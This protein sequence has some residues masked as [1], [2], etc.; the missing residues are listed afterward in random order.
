MPHLTQTQRE[1]IFELQLASSTQAEIAKAIGHHQSTISRELLR[2]PAGP[3]IG[4]LPDRAEKIARRRR[5]QAKEKVT[6]WY[7]HI[8]LLKYVTEKLTCKSHY[9]P[10]QIAGRIELDYP[11]D[12]QMRVSH[13][14]IYQYIWED[15]RK[16]G[17][18]WKCL[19]QS[20]KKRKKR[21]GKKDSRGVIPNKISIDK[22][23]KEVEDKNNPGNFEGDL[24]IG[25]QHK[26]AINT[27]VERKS[28]LLRAIKMNQK[29][30]EE[31][32]EATVKAYRDIPAELRKTMTYDN[33]TEM[34]RHEEIASRLGISI[35]FAHPY[36]SW[37]RGLNENTN[38]L[39]RQYFPKGTDFTKITQ[40][41]LD[42]VVGAI[43][44][45]PRKTLKYR[46]P[47]EVFEEMRLCVSG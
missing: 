4:Y 21:Y 46:T 43:N 23:P 2:N 9:S 37:E 42:E 33:G 28:K 5:A 6:K 47:N 14:S 38:G 27:Q 10:E 17:N 16:G 22:R 29:T 30:A 13:E 20:R 15:K 45:R 41:D 25:H 35:Y 24:I 32:V 8:P 19:R 7:E 39:I 36:H 44:N 11:K 3:R 34:A 18:L 31:M 40:A 1:K 12:E 26:G